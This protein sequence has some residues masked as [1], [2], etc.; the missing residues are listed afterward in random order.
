MSKQPFPLK[1]R[2]VVETFEKNNGNQKKLHY[3]LCCIV[4]V[5]T[6]SVNIS[7]LY[8]RIKSVYSTSKKYNKFSNTHKYNEYLSH[9]FTNAIGKTLPSS[10][11]HGFQIS[12]PTSYVMTYIVPLVLLLFLGNLTVVSRLLT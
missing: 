6:T 9:V 11:K 5:D 10:D 12:G 8:S 4:R 3:V 2:L 7:S 1:N